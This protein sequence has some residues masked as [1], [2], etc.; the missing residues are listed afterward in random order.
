MNKQKQKQNSNHPPSQHGFL[1]NILLTPL[2]TIVAAR[3]KNEID[4]VIHFKLIFKAMPNEM[5]RRVSCHA[6][7]CEFD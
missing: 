4:D 1:F 5:G 7:V 6:C 2:T 3:Q